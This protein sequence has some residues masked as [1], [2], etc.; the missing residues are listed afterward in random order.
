MKKYAPILK[1]FKLPRMEID[2]DR[3]DHGLVE[4]K[5]YEIIVVTT[6]SN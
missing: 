6:N 1:E 3:N 5:F 4:V 2:T